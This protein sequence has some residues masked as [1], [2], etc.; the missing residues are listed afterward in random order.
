M[1]GG[2]DVKCYYYRFDTNA[3]TNELQNLGAVDESVIMFVN[4][5]CN[6]ASAYIYNSDDSIDGMHYIGSTP[7]IKSIW[8][9]FR[10]EALLINEDIYYGAYPYITTGDLYTKINYFI[11]TLA[12]LDSQETADT[13]KLAFDICLKYITE[14]TEDEFWGMCDL[15]IAPLS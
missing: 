4:L 5:F 14:I 11:K 13:F 12:I 10:I 8:N 7:N 9:V 2:S 15:P 6:C 1:G 3:L